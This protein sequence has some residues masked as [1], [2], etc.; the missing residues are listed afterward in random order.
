MRKF[1]Q[2]KEIKNFITISIF[3]L[4]FGF[5]FA[6]SSYFFNPKYK[7]TILLEPVQTESITSQ[8]SSLTGS[9]G[10]I[11]Q[12]AGFDFSSLGANERDLTDLAMASV[13]SRNFFDKYL[14][15]MVM[16]NMFAVDYYDPNSKKIIIDSKDYDVELNEWVPKALPRFI[17]NIRNKKYDP[18]PSFEVSHKIF[19]KKYFSIDED[20]KTGF[21]T[22]NI[23]HESPVI[24]KE[25]AEY[26]YLSINEFLRSEDSLKYKKIIDLLN[27]ELKKAELESVQEA[28]SKLIE[29]Q[30]ASYYLIN[31]SENYVFKAIELPYEAEKKYFPRRTIFLILGIIFGSFISFLYLYR[32]KILTIVLSE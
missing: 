19:Y 10:S 1:L 5:I 16:V 17:A 3:G 9:L 25:W 15:E 26:I 20:L 13:V 24:A 11:G 22:I 7:T 2:N 18:K 12:L 30:T 29:S 31:T 6:V 27:D 8:I 23:N 32:Q 14:Y 4:L 21:V 28:I